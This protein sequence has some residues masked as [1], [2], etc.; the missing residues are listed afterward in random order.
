TAYLVPVS[1]LPALREWARGKDWLG[2]W[3]PEA[4][5][6][7]N[8][9][10]GA[11]PDDPQWSAADGSIEHWNTHCGGPM[12][13]GLTPP[14]P[15]SRGTRTLAAAGYGGTGTSRDASADGET[16]GWVPSR[17][18][19]D[20]LGLTHGADFAWNDASGTAIHDPSTTAGGPATLT[21]RRD[22]LPQLTS[23]GLTL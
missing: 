21:M 6:I 14:P 12:P 13:E 1:A 7:P 18:L 10:L 5:D 9:L 8:V 15:G 11:Y 23:A 3:M 20:V 2:R 19:Y 22:L 17:R 4:P 16:T